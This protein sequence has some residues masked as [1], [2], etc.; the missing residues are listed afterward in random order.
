MCGSCANESAMKAAFF[1][2]RARERGQDVGAFTK[3][4]LSSCMENQKPGSPDLCG[5]SV[6]GAAS[7]EL[8]ATQS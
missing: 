1:A 7:L 2:Y 6:V 5:P 8:T 4:E 3:E